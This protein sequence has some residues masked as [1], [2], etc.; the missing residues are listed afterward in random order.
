MNW[1]VVLVVSAVLVPSSGHA[2]VIRHDRDDAAFLDLADPYRCTVAFKDSDPAGLSGMGTLIDPQWV[3]T[4][5]HVAAALNPRTIAEIA[6][7]N[8]SLDRIVVHPD[9]HSDAD[10]KADIALVRLAEPVAGCAPVRLY[11]GAD[12]VGL[13]VTFV[14]R[15]TT[16]TGLTGV[17][18]GGW[19]GQLRAATNRVV[20]A[21]GPLLQFRFD[22]P[23]DDGVTAL[24]GISGEA[25]SGGPAYLEREGVLFTIG[26]SSS[27]DPRPAGRKR[28]AYGVLE[29]YSRVSYFAEWIREVIRAD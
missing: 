2:I 1:R 13:V 8:Y 16:G 10:L 29:Y 14:G 18:A 24:E 9:W 5:A 15:G 26:V 27:Q 21:D 20:R 28:G 3:L 19:D 11:T 6:A 4:A 7:R 23:G 22:A 12:E 25:D 17:E